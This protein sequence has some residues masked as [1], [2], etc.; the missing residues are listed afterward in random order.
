MSR[1]KRDEET[2]VASLFFP[3]LKEYVYPLIVL[4]FG[5]RSRDTVEPALDSLN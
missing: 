2:R 3:F 4:M 5:V 1:R